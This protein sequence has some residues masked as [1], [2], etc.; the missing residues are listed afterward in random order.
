[1]KTNKSY[2]LLF[3]A[4]AAA[5]SGCSSDEL[6][7]TSFVDNG[8]PSANTFNVCVTDGGYTAISEGTHT[9]AEE[10]DYQ[11]VFTAGD[12]I[13]VFAVKDDHIVDG[14]NNLCLTA[15]V[16]GDN[17]IWKD[18]E[19]LPH[20]PAGV[21]Y[22]AYYPYQSALVG[23][24]N[25]K[26]SDAA[27]FFARVIQA[28]TPAT[29]QSTYADYTAQDLMIAQGSVKGRTLSFSMEHRMAL[30]VIDLPKMKYKFTNDPTIL[31]YTISVPGTQF[32]NFSPLRM[33]NDAYR[34]LV[35]P[36]SSS[37]DEFFGCYTDERDA[38]KEWKITADN[39]EKGKF[40]T[41]TVDATAEGSIKTLEK[42]HALAVGDFF[43]KDGSLLDGTAELTLKEKSA[44]IGVVFWLGDATKKDRILRSD[45]PGCTHGLVVALEDAASNVAW[46][47]PSSSVQD[48]LND[49][50]PG[51]YLVFMNNIGSNPMDSL[52][53]IQGYNNTKAIEEFNNFTNGPYVK[54]V[55]EVVAYRTKVP[56]PANCSDWYLPSVKE[57]TLLCGDDVD[58]LATAGNGRNMY[59]LLNNSSFS[60][61]GSKLSR[62]GYWSSTEQSAGEAYC[63]GLNYVRMAVKQQKASWQNMRCVLAF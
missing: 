35:K 57:V 21:T 47:Y 14:V 56:A 16:D 22:Y 9:R 4:F 58:N 17:I 11:T 19:K 8:S 29:N 5:L 60:K 45:H 44:C 40:K 3:L 23:T 48:W 62:E 31:D 27:G 39:I 15:S 6:P 53:N 25:L 52:N 34:Y 30:V 38:I 10:K 13:G 20:I 7:G 42:S 33:D 54:I 28:W 2:I 1:M 50:R 61:L 51:E 49:N 24:L 41:F 12:K 36:S 55:S 18:G 32:Y 43:M 37:G 59:D 26:A 63:W 46:Q